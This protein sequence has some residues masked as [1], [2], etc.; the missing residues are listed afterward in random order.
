MGT[1]L[2]AQRIVVRYTA[3]WLG[4]VYAGSQLPIESGAGSVE[5]LP[6]L[7]ELLG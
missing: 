7:D 1:V 2:V 3:A 4:I 5:H 6:K